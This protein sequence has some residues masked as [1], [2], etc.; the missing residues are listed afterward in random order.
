MTD[1]DEA[2][3]VAVV[4]MIVS[5]SRAWSWFAGTPVSVPRSFAAGVSAGA[6]EDQVGA[7]GP[8]GRRVQRE[9][10]GAAA[11]DVVLAE[12]AEDGIVTA[13]TLDVVVP[14]EALSKDGLST[15]SPL[16]LRKALAPLKIEPSPWIVSLP[17]WPKISSLAAPAGDGVV[18]EAVDDAPTTG[19]HVA[20]KP[21]MLPPRLPATPFWMSALW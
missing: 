18:A 2:E 19:Q 13:A 8:L 7:V 20:A 10:I 16:L 4:T 14:S 17:S 21:S 6:A 5:A 15:R 3:D 9:E 11:D 12:A 1:A